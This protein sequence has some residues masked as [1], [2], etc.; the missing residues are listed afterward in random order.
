MDFAAILQDDKTFP[1]SAEIEISGQKVSLGTIRD[2]T[3]KQQSAITERV[4]ALERERNEVRELATKAAELQSQLQAQ[5]EGSTTR[6][7]TVPTDDDFEQDPFWTPVRK[8]TKSFESTINELKETQK[9]LYDAVQKASTIWAEDRWERQFE[10]VKDKLKGDKYKDYNFEKVRD[11]AA[12]NKIVDRYGLPDMRKAVDEI[13]KEDLLETIKKQAYEDG[14]RA[15]QQKGRLSTM[16]RPTSAE[17]PAP[18]LKDA[19]V[20]KHGL[21]GLGDDVAKDPDL[22]NMLSELGALSPEDIV[23]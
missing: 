4:N 16:A 21:D 19:A 20:A 2:L 23:Q 17:G 14:L 8:R 11:Y 6:T 12:Q 22:M 1:D 15:G 13:T 10:T 9:K 3:K 7:A 18:S 5:L